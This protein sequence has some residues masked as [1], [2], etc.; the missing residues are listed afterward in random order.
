[1]VGEI[2][3]ERNEKNKITIAGIGP[4]SPDYLPP[5]TRRRAEEADVIFGSE[6]ALD[7]FSHSDKKTH[8]F[9]GDLEGLREK[10]DLNFPDRRVLV[11]VTGA[12]GLYSLASYLTGHF[13]R[14]HLEIIPAVSSLQLA[15][16]RAGLTWQDARFISLHGRDNLNEL[17][18]MVR[19][20]EKIGVFT[21][22]ENS[23]DRLA[24]YLLAEGTANRMAMVGENLSRR[25]ENIVED[26]L[27]GLADMSFADLNVMIIYPPD[28]ERGEENG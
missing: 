24:S 7:L 11:L 20:G 18:E 13:P 6:R 23:P 26:R 15:F 17:A 3:N 19:R 9:A 2:G 27:S 25:D 10:I 5:I 1:M 4:G 28:H 16:A 8:E 21:D 22:K 14:E 12:P